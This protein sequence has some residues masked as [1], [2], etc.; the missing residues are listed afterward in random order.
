LF[1]VPL[2][3][4]L[5]S[6]DPELSARRCPE[7]G[8]VL[9]VGGW[10]VLFFSLSGCKLPTYILPAFPWLALAMGYY[11]TRSGWVHS[12]WLKMVVYLSFAVLFVGHNLLLPWYAGYRAPSAHLA[13]LK[14]YCGDKQVPVIC[15]PRNCDSAAFYI[16]R[17]DLQSYRSKQT[18]L[19]VGYLQTQPRTVL[20]LTHRHSLKGLGYALTPDLYIAEVRHFGLGN[21]PG[22]SEGLGQKLTWFLGETSL[23]LCDVA[24]VKRRNRLVSASSMD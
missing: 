20:L 22:L 5:L 21:I 4:F 12:L 9:L 1:V 2:L 14:S 16:G 19:L 18:H 6:A 3:R 13:E 7:L 23:G 24:V 10:C 15:Y 8:F 11:L 17:D